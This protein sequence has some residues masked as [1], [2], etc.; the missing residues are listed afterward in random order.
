[1]LRSVL[2][3]I[4][5]L[6]L[7]GLVVFGMEMLGH[8]LY[9]HPEGLDPQ[10][11]EAVR[12]YVATAPT[13]ALLTV[14]L[15]WFVGTLCGATLAVRVSGRPRPAYVV[16]AVQLTAGVLNLVM[17]GAHPWWFWMPGLLVFP[18]AAWLAARAV[19]S[20]PGDIETTARQRAA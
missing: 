20:A 9:P 18:A 2:A 13:G 16:G 15:G 17:L 5:G 10:D 1:M 19:P 7:G 8:I 6:V 14:L 3:V 4:L 12:A 11:M